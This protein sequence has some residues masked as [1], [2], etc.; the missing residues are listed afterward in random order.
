MVIFHS[1]V[2][3]YQRVARLFS[4]LWKWKKPLDMAL[5]KSRKCQWEFQDP[6]MEVPIP[7]IRPIF[8][9]LVSGNIARKYGQKYGT[10]TYLHLLDPLQISHWNGTASSEARLGARWSSFISCN[11]SRARSQLRIVSQAWLKIRGDSRYLWR[12]SWAME[13][14]ITMDMYIYIWKY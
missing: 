7:Y 11:S 8:Q 12:S 4:L 9:A 6:K 14:K 2:T 10:F 13:T 1:N 5:Q 3:V